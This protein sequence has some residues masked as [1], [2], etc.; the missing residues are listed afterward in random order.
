M[1]STTA[2]VGTALAVCVSMVALPTSCGDDQ[3][4][5]CERLATVVELDALADSISASDPGAASEEVD[6]FAEVAA[7]APEAVRGDMTAVAD[8][9]E[10]VDVALTGS[11][12]DPDDLELRRRRSTSSW[13]A[14]PR[15]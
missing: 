15:T 8:A 14:R 7:E 13:V 11:D 9:L 1:R 4:P 12:A 2:R 5:W 3:D 6:R 10:Q